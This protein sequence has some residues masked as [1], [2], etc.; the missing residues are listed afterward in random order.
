MHKK[1]FTAYV[2]RLFTRT[3]KPS[4]DMTHIVLIGTFAVTVLLLVLLG[5]SYVLLG[6][7]YVLE[8]ILIGFVIL[9]Y[10]CFVSFFVYKKHI[11]IAAWM[12]IALYGFVGLAILHTWGLNAPIG[13]LMLGFVVILATVTLGVSY[14]IP[15]AISVVCLLLLTQY[16]SVLGLSQPDRSMLDN[17]STYGDVASY[18]VILGIF[19]LIAWLFG[20]KTERILER[21]VRAE[22]ELQH[23]R[24]SLAKHVEIQSQAL[25][26]A[27]RKE[28]DQLYAFAELGQLTTIILHELAN[29]LSI[30]ALDIDDLGDRNESSKSIEN[31]KESISYIDD[32]IDQVRNQINNGNVIKT[33]NAHD[34]AT[35]T[36][37]RLRRN[38]KQIKIELNLNDESDN[39]NIQG[40]PLRLSQALTIL[41]NNAVQASRNPFKAIVIN[42]NADNH[43][44]LITVKDFGTGI[45][46]SERKYLFQPKQSSK[47]AGHGIGLYV[48]KQIIE[49][50][51]KGTLS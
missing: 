50:H 41:V 25:M 31:A 27:Q 15:T 10:L 21:A 29:H 8:R 6:H 28:L 23:E 38:L 22:N 5:I 24:D 18:S 33:F 12:I 39:C 47:N 7:E 32:I 35:S 46:R 30:L 17:V 40:D 20:R 45:S 19:A 51:F 11:R 42:I 14:I 43:N 49:M 16:L 9:F 26:N 4:E 37:A 34:L 13:I 44:V 1:I 3:R 36:V 2:I 48:T